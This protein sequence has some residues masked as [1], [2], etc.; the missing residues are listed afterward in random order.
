MVEPEAVVAMLRPKELVGLET[1]HVEPRPR[2][3][4]VIYSK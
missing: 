4:V 3:K 1:N 2:F